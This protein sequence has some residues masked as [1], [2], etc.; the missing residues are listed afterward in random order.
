[1]SEKQKL[2]FTPGVC[3]RSSGT[4]GANGFAD[5]AADPRANASPRG[6]QGNPDCGASRA[7]LIAKYLD[8]L[9]LHRHEAILGRAGLAIPRS[10]RAQWAGACGVQQ[11]PI[12]DAMRAQMLSGRVLHADETP[13]PILKPRLGRTHRTYLSSYSTSEYDP[14]RIVI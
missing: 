5:V 1:V 11:L 14:L 9:P 4:C 10:N 7:P 12:V 6:R 3:S 2:D 13:V 8:H